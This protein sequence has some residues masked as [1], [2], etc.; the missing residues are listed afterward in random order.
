M[1]KSPATKK[2]HTIGYKCIY[3]YTHHTSKMLT[4]YLEWLFLSKENELYF[5]VYAFVV[6]ILYLQ[7]L[8]N[9]PK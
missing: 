3:M 5:L 1:W 2:L 9:E 4:E 8:Y 7:A 6:F